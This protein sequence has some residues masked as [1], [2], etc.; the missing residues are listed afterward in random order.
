MCYLCIMKWK[1]SSIVEDLRNMGLDVETE[2]NPH[3]ECYCRDIY[4]TV[5]DETISVVG[6]SDEGSDLSDPDEPVE[7][8]IL[9]EVR[10]SSGNGGLYRMSDEATRKAYFSITDYFSG[11]PEV[12]I[13]DNLKD[14]F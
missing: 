3:G 13:V 8:I 10:T 7:D 14:Y 4:V 5:G 2:K 1:T 6:F 9:V 12:E 11:Y